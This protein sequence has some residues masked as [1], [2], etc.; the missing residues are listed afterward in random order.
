MFWVF[1]VFLIH[2]SIFFFRALV[3]KPTRSV[4]IRR[5]QWRCSVNVFWFL[6][7]FSFAVPIYETFNIPWNITIKKI[8]KM[9]NYNLKKKITNMWKNI[10]SFFFLQRCK[11]NI[12]IILQVVQCKTHVHTIFLNRVPRSLRCPIVGEGGEKDSTVKII[13]NLNN[14]IKWFLQNNSK[15]NYCIFPCHL[16]IYQNFI[17]LSK[18]LA[19]ILT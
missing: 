11:L 1:G 19:Q 16:T 9:W 5:K 13:E 2:V 3:P 4:T 7:F 8:T 14:I 15:T 18:M 17:S 12:C 6:L 10:Q